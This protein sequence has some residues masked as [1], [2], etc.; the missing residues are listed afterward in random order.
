MIIAVTGLNTASEPSAG[1]AV[2]KSLKDRGG[3]DLIGLVYEPLEACAYQSGFVKRVYLL[4]YP[5]IDS[6]EYLKRL[7]QIKT[8]AGIDILIP[9]RESEIPL[10]IQNIPALDRMGI[11]TLLP[12]RESMRFIS[13]G[14]LAGKLKE[15]AVSFS[16]PAAE[17]EADRISFPSLGK[18][19]GRNGSAFFD[20]KGEEFSTAIL[21]DRNHRITG[22]VSIKR[23]LISP[24]GGTWM[25][26]TIDDELSDLAEEIVFQTDWTGPMTINV[27]RSENGDVYVRNV[28]PQFPDWINFAA[29]AGVNLPAVLVDILQGFDHPPV[30]RIVPG[31]L[32]VRMSIDIV[33]EI[34]RFGAF[35]LTGEL[36]YD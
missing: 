5:E 8:N 13:P 32:F 31:K 30:S 12:H 35:S 2:L 11:R 28:L 10:L 18:A 17:G 20:I 15:R 33:T 24:G 27:I 36:F 7:S 14:A 6:G 23:L 22:S 16:L 21:A 3:H 26:L 4:P 29:E 9:N 1:Y 19:P 34:D 25:G